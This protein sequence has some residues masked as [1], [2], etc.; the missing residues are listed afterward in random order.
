MAN[1]ISSNLYPEHVKNNY[2]SILTYKQPNL[3]MGKGSDRHSK[4]ET[5]MT[6]TLS[7]RTDDQHHSSAKTCTP[8]VRNHCLLT[9]MA[10]SSEVTVTGAGEN[11]E[12]LESSYPAAGKVKWCGHIS[13][14]PFILFDFPPPCM[15]ICYFTKTILCQ[16]SRHSSCRRV[17]V[18]MELKLPHWLH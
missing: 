14:L 11:V 18:H 12:K 15:F 3:K 10:I 4:E 8:A 16:K 1:H 5:Q 7:T 13:R 9:S 6:M 17:V 2:N